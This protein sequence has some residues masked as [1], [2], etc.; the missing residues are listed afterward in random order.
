MNDDEENEEDYDLGQVLN[1]I[2]A[3]A[4]ESS[5]QGADGDGDDDEEVA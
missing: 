1:E 2:A 4:M 3:T 5:N